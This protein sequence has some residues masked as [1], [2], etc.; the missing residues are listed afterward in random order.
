[1]KNEKTLGSGMNHDA[2]SNQARQKNASESKP[3]G[4]G[5]S[6]RRLLVC[7]GGKVFGIRDIFRKGEP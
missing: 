5:G 2:P 6:G 7:V 1:M 4:N 3:K